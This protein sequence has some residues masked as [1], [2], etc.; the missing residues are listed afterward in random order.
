MVKVGDPSAPAGT[1]QSEPTY[2][3]PGPAAPTP[4]GTKVASSQ[5][6]SIQL[7]D[8]PIKENGVNGC[9]IDDVIEWCRNILTN[10]NTMQGR[11]FSCRENAMA[12]TKLDEA[13]M[14]LQRRTEDR[15]KHGVE[16][17]SLA[18]GA[19]DAAVAGNSPDE[20]NLTGD[21]SGTPPYPGAG[22]PTAVAPGE[23]ISIERE[24]PVT[25]PHPAA[26]G[27]Q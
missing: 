7:Q 21:G 14:W 10:F 17:T 6:I 13:L 27:N 11:K 9:Q 2:T 3:R 25:V 12:I 8:G 16:G 20:S 18:I 24:V 19:A 1:Q 15:T 5:F 22:T 4:E 26:Q 23:A